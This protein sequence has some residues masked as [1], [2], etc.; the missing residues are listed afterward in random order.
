MRKLLEWLHLVPKSK[1]FDPEFTGSYPR[2]EGAKN[3][4]IGGAPEDMN[5]MPATGDPEHPIYDGS[6]LPKPSQAIH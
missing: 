1:N 3:A 6:D 4:V 2:N 5:A